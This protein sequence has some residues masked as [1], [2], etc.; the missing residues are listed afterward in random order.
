M[1]CLI[2]SA[3]YAQ[4]EQYSDDGTDSCIDCEAKN[5]G[6]ERSCL[7]FA[8]FHFTV[9][10]DQINATTEK[11]KW[12]YEQEILLATAW[13]GVNYFAQYNSPYGLSTD[14]N[15]EEIQ[16]KHFRDV[17]TNNLANKYF[18]KLDNQIKAITNYDEVA[19]RN[20]NLN[21]KILDIRKRE[22]TTNPVYGDLKYKGKFLRSMTDAEVNSLL[23]T[24]LVTRDNQRAARAEYSIRSSRLQRMLNEGYIANFLAGNLL[25]HYKSLDYEDAIRFMTTYDIRIAIEDPTVPHIEPNKP[26]FLNPNVDYT[27]ADHEAQH[28]NTLFLRTGGNIPPMDGYTPPSNNELS[29]EDALFTLARTNYGYATNKYITERPEVV[30]ELKEYFKYSQ[31]DLNSIYLIERTFLSYTEVN[32]IFPIGF[33]PNRPGEKFITEDYFINPNRLFRR[34]QITSDPSNRRFRLFENV[35]HAL[36][37]SPNANREAEGRMT[38][39]IMRDNG[40][41][42]SNYFTY[43]EI[44]RLFYYDSRAFNI[45]TEFYIT[46]FFTNDIG[47]KL[48][49][50]GVRFLSMLDRPYVIEGTRALLNNQPFDFAFR[51]KVYDVSKALTLNQE[52][53]DWL[54]TNRNKT[55]NLY[56]YYS[57]HTN[58]GT[59]SSEEVIFV[60]NAINVLMANPS[61]NPLLGADCRSFEYAQPPGALQKGCAV[62]NFDHRFYTAGIRPNG[63]PYYGEIDIN[64][65]II[66]FTMPNVITNGQAAN[67]TAIA[68]TAAI[69][70]ADVYFFNNPDVSEF[71][72]KDVF[73]DALRTQLAIVGGSFSFTAE[74][75]SIPSPAPYITSVLGIS[76]PFD[77]D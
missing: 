51:K 17:E 35:L 27:L 18:T 1:V 42:L 74:P 21:S 39:H 46:A 72:L 47:I 4:I 58:A 49:Q 19:L 37:T 20:A 56:N 3:T 41:E 61:A 43:D 15:F 34:V 16:R 33:A 30:K 11:D 70:E 53:K 44:A 62:K 69:K 6:S 45:G 60:T 29:E 25:V 40:F 38:D 26:P 5:S 54:I 31:Y 55:E 76:N 75:F 50:N 22:G 7:C 13:T 59:W 9:F 71:G 14:Y 63:S 8:P 77:C 52:Q 32:P 67:L 10:N 2:S 65:S 73:N 57:S 24:E 48:W 36:E 23:N 66:Y 12:L 68:V 28:L 64:T